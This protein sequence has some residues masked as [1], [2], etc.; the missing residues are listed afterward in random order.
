M[1]VEGG[2]PLAINTKTGF[3][4]RDTDRRMHPFQVLSKL[5]LESFIQSE[6]FAKNTKTGFLARDTLPSVDSLIECA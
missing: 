5:K 6:L 4:A 1:G 2:T 3:L